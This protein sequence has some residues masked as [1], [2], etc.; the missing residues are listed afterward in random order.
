[1]ANED[2]ITVTNNENP[3]INLEITSY[4]NSL[5]LSFIQSIEAVVSVHNTN[6]NAHLNIQNALETQIALKANSAEVSSALDSKVDKIT[7]KGLSTN[8]F[9]NALKSNYD[10]AY[11]N[12]HTHS[13]KTILDALTNSGSGTSF[14]SNDGTYKEVSS[15]TADTSNMPT[16]SNT[17]LTGT[18][19]TTSGSATVTGTGTS[20]TTEAPAGT[21]I[22]IAGTYYTVSSVT[23]NTSLT[24]TTNASTT[25]SA[26]TAYYNNKITFSAGFCYDLSTNIKI[27]NTAM[28]KSLSATFTGGSGNGGLD[29]GSKANSTWYAV[30]AIS[31]ADGTSDFLFSTSSTAPTMPSGYTNKR[32]IGWIKTDSSGNIIGFYQKGDFITYNSNIL[33]Y[34]ATSAVAG[35][36]LTLS[37]PSGARAMLLCG[38]VASGT[39]W[40]NMFLADLNNQSSHQAFNVCAGT[41]VANSVDINVNNSSQIGLTTY[42]SG[43]TFSIGTIGYIDLR[44]KK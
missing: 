32:R 30:F 33:D 9:T 44:G 21:I 8:D 36:S 43:G 19:N 17:V 40:G 14:L 1:M 29:T 16:L 31:K 6:E 13:N 20:F 7:G 38:Y 10:T 25:Y 5:D 26:I 37:V 4:N 27:T 3:P 22:N 23:N 15:Y 35:Y 18:I 11:T 2:L 34:T 41:H 28:T 42:L 24:L 12:N 39:S